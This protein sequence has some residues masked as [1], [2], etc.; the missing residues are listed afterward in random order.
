[1]LDCP[2]T[3]RPISTGIKVDDLTAE[4]VKG[5]SLTL[6][7]ILPEA[8]KTESG[9]HKEN[10]Q[11]RDDKMKKTTMLRKLFQEPGFVSLRWYMTRCRQES[12]RP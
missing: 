10:I 8:E 7:V 12:P 6:S 4:R 1:M 2:V 3:G 5:K 11:N 9:R